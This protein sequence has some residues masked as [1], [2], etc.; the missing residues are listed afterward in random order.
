MTHRGPFQ[1]LT[2]CDSVRRGDTV[3]VIKIGIRCFCL[4]FIRKISLKLIASLPAAEMRL[5]QN[6]EVCP[7]SY[8]RFKFLQSEVACCTQTDI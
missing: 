1:P 2:F 8:R 5:G 6:I 7:S 4:V 3:G